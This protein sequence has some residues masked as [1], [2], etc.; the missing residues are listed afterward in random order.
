M[1]AD[2]SKPP[3]KAALLLAIGGKPKGPAGRE[4]MLES[5]S[6]DGMG[7]DADVPGAGDV[8]DMAAADAM[9]AFKSGDVG[10]L[11]MALTDFVKACQSED[12]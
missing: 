1:A 10:A 11:S 12:Y 4:P 2:G 6:D 3:N 8:K 7:L 9:A 5:E